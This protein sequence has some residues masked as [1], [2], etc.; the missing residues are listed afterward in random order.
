M[1]YNG[2]EFLKERGNTLTIMENLGN[3]ATIKGIGDRKPVCV[4]KGSRWDAY[5]TA[6]YQGKPG[7]L[8]LVP[9]DRYDIKVGIILPEYVTYQGHKIS[10]IG[11]ISKYTYHLCPKKVTGNTRVRV[12]CKLGNIEN[13]ILS[14]M[15]YGD[16]RKLDLKAEGLV[17]HHDSAVWDLRYIALV[18]KEE[19]QAIHDKIGH[20]THKVRYDYDVGDTTPTP[21]FF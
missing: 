20:S 17:I 16:V 13:I 5:C 11:A 8:V 9:E 18:T 14:L 21:K 12:K 15:L 10:V 3:A 19:H 6:I 2:L 4:V 1:S 7:E